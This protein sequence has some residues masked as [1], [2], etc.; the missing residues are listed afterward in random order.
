MLN[1]TGKDCPNSRPVICDGIEYESLT[2]FKEKNNYLK[3]NLNGWLNGVV[4]M[5]KYWYDKKLHYKDLGFDI[6][7]LTKVS[8]N[9]YRK[10]MADDLIFNTLQE[11][12]DYL[13]TKPVNLS[14]YL[15]GKKSP[16]IEIIQHNLRYEGEE[17]HKFKEPDRS[18]LGRKVKY[19][20][21]GYI[22]ESQKELSQYLGV[23]QGTLYSWLKGINKMPFKIKNKNIKRIE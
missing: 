20:C 13:G 12:A 4:G 17:F 1:K 10:V 9:R 5:P 21:D 19:E 22:F 14:L 11:C 7:K 15:N 23:K 3:G 18:R 16:P 2:E 8:E 6:V